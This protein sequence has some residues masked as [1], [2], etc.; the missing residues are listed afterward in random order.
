M[1]NE[2]I[3]L[4]SEQVFEEE[5]MWWLIAM[6]FYKR[7]IHSRDVPELVLVETAEL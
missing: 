4:T 1:E 3:D 7:I 5:N 6:P 2:A